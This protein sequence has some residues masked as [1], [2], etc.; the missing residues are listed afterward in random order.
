MDKIDLLTTS[1]VAKILGVTRRRIVAMITAG[2]LPAQIMGDGQR[3]IYLI[4][5]ADLKLVKNRKPG[6]P[7]GVK[8]EK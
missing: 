8:A 1:E 2:Q 6:R 5:R 3:P 4:A 7:K